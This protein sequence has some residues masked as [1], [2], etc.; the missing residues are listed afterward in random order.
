LTVS[1]IASILIIGGF[2]TSTPNAFSTYGGNHDD[3]DDHDDCDNGHYGNNHDD[4]CDN[5]P[6]DPCDCEK[7]DTLKFILSTPSAEINNDFRIEIFKKLD[8]INNPDKMLYEIAGVLNGEERHIQ[9]SN[10]GKDKLN[11]N[12]VFAIYRVVDNELVAS[13]EIHTSCSQSLYIGQIVMDN[14]YAL[15]ITDGL[16]NGKTSISASD[17]LTCG[18][19]PE[20]EQT[21]TIVIRNTLTKDNGGE[22]TLED[23]SYKVTDELGIETNLDRDLLDPSIHVAEIPK[24]TYTLSQTIA[25]AVT[26]TYTE[27]LITGDEQCPDTTNESFKIKKDKTV[28]CTIY[29]D[30]NGD[31]SGGI[32]FRNFSMKVQLDA[33]MDNDSCD[34]FADAADKDPCIQIVNF[35]NG[36]IAI[37]DSSLVSTT[38][39]ILFSVA[40]ESLDIMD[41]ALEPDCSQDRIIRHN[42]TSDSLEDHNG[43]PIMNPSD[44]LVVL[45]QCPGMATDQV[46]NVNYVMINPLL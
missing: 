17:P 12:T 1:V 43:D 16:K 3:D 42:S 14:G 46:Y 6:K 29:N 15:E 18:D 41:G 7:P 22:A 35:E 4:D 10:F 8:D 39:I 40:Q 24:G 11:S 45:L 5:E 33:P 32:V 34:Q 13:M 2:V 30:D 37:V 26:G 27:V 38:T 23:F 31:G 25:S 9:A 28:S 20:P 36:D 44:N 21:G 19:E